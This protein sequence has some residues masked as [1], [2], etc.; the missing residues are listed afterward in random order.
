MSCA[1]ELGRCA[2]SVGEIPVGALIVCGGEIIAADFNGRETEKNAL[3]HAECAVID[4]ACR[5]LGGWRLPGCELY[6]TLEPCI[7]CAGGVISSRLPRVIFGSN[8][9]KG[10]FFGS[11]ADATAFGLNHKPV[12]TKGILERECGELLREFF[13]RKRENP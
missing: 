2:A 11:V 10:G 1:I 5:A 13:Q 6:V 4:K 12:I 7:M 8:D 9:P 3:Y